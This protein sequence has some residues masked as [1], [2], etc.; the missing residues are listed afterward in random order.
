M[1]IAPLAYIQGLSQGWAAEQILEGPFAPLLPPVLR[2]SVHSHGRWRML[3]FL[4]HSQTPNPNLDSGGTPSISTA[5]SSQKPPGPPHVCSGLLPGQMR[6][7]GSPTLRTVVSWK[8]FRENGFHILKAPG[9]QQFLAWLFEAGGSNNP[10]PRNP[11]HDITIASC[12]TREKGRL[13]ETERPPSVLLRKKIKIDMTPGPHVSSVATAA[14]A[15]ISN[16][17]GHN[18]AQKGHLSKQSH[19]L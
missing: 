7:L 12:Q 5:I 19:R 3:Q 1:P 10:A 14:P 8:Q 4:T 18:V 6:A 13:L 17:V 15:P 16:D 2:H 9:F 11:N